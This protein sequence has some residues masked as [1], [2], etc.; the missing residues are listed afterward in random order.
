MKIL[1]INK[2][3][4]PKGGDAV[5]TLTTGNLLASKGHEVNY[6]G[7]DHPLNPDYPFRDYFVENIDYHAECSFKKKAMMAVSLLY[8]FEAKNRLKKLL[9]GFKPDIVHFNNFAHQISPSVLHVLKKYNIP[10]VMTMRDYKL[11]CASYSMLLNGTPCERCRNGMYY[12]CFINKCSKNSYAKSLLNTLEMYL[13][14]KVLH[15]YGLIDTYISPSMFLKAKCEE[16]GFKEKIEY[17]PNFVNPAEFIPQPKEED[18]TIIYFGRLSKEKGLFTLIRAMRGIDAILRIIG[19]GPARNDLEA[20]VRNSN[21]RNVEFLGFK[22]G[23]EL[24]YLIKKAMFVVLPSE[25]YENNPRTI[26]EAFASGKPAL[27]ARIGGI[28]E[29]VRDGETGLTFEPGNANDLAEKISMLLGNSALRIEMGKN[30]RTLAETELNP[31]KHYKRLME[32]Y[33]MAIKKNSARK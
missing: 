5:S 25:W 17:L 26:I 22:T 28:P 31:E 8:S 14:H 12:Q 24:K 3:L 16:M 20:A 27:G 1:L 2:S 13:H 10:S 7:M 21:S 18:N 4:Y 9:K 29:L 6:W 19:D 30:A 15:L 11:V 23:D 32:I 33:D